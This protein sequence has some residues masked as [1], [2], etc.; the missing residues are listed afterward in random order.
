MPLNFKLSIFCFKYGGGMS[1]ELITQR[2]RKLGLFR[3]HGILDLGI[4]G[5]LVTW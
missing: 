5:N 4:R 2:C 1:T 3:F